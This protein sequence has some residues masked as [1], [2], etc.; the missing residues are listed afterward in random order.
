MNRIRRFH[1]VRR[2]AG[3][4]T[5]LAAALLAAASAAPAAFALPVPPVGGGD[6]IPL[7]PPQVRTVVVGGTPG[8]Q[9]ALIAAGAAILAAAVAVIL[10]RA[11]AARQHQA[12][13]SA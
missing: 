6:G 12:A 5:V 10:D 3:A 4:L 9:I 8:W 2:V 1:P 7:P 13:P 11:L